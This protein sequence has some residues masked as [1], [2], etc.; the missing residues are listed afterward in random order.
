MNETRAELSRPMDEAGIRNNFDQECVTTMRTQLEKLFEFFATTKE[1]V[2]GFK[3][4]QLDALER[5]EVFNRLRQ[6]EKA[7]R[8]LGEQLDQL[9]N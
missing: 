2:T 7:L 5:E 4:Y 1:R 9:V 3:L 6:T 8:A